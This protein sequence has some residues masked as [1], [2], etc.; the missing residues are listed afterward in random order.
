MTVTQVSHDGF[1]R[2]FTY[3]ETIPGKPFEGRGYECACDIREKQAVH[4]KGCPSEPPPDRDNKPW[5]HFKGYA[6]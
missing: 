4:M 1:A 5:E 2:T 3:R 6:S